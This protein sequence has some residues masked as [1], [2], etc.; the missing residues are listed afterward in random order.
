MDGL[1]AISNSTLHHVDIE[2]TRKGLEDWLLYVLGRRG[3][4]LLVYWKVIQ[5][6]NLKTALFASRGDNISLMQVPPRFL[7]AP[8][9]AL[10]LI[11]GTE[12]PQICGTGTGSM[13]GQAFM[14]I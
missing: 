6:P 8:T 12:V 5:I 2:D 3:V 1:F 13:V 9:S 11:F 10:R 4:Q 14:R 7:T